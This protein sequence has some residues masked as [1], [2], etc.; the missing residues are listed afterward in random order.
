M[1]AQ[2]GSGESPLPDCGLPSFVVPSQDGKDKRTLRV[3]FYKGTDPIR[4]DST[5]VI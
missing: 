5:I 2:S 3:P 4:E 1:P